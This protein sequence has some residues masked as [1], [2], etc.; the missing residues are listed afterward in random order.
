MTIC[1]ANACHFRIWITFRRQG[2]QT[3]GYIYPGL[4]NSAYRIRLKV[5]HSRRAGFDGRL[6]HV[7]SP[8][9]FARGTTASGF[10]SPSA[11]SVQSITCTG[12]IFTVSPF[13]TAYSEQVRERKRER[14]KDVSSKGYTADRPGIQYK[15]ATRGHGV[16]F[17]TA[18]PPNARRRTS[19]G[20]Q[21]ACG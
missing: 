14:E 18:A 10:S 2:C 5:L 13:F 21:A 7:F 4:M 6:R 11:S 15:N 20:Q 1:L 16:D 8:N 19:S 12:S 9:V 3:E 17:D